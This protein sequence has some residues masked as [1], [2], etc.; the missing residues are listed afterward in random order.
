MHRLAAR[1]LRITQTGGGAVWAWTI[2]ELYV[3]AA[4]GGAAPAAVEADGAELARGLR[5]EGVRRLYAD[6]GWASRVALA[7]PAIWIPPANLQVDDYGFTGPATMLL[8]PFHWAAGTGVLLESADAEAFAEAARAGGLAF[9]RRSLAGLSLFV[10]VSIPSPGPLLS[11]HA[12]GVTAARRSKRARLAVDGDPATRWATARPRAAGDW[13]RVDLPAAR[14]LR[15]VRLSVDESRRPAAGA[16]PGGLARRRGLG[17][18]R[19]EGAVGAQ[20][21]MGWLRSSR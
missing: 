3:Y 9:A 6:H 18:P 14:S 20:V 11:T 13:F 15:G 1:H 7:D 16:G 4:I 10:H 2:R 8:P 5:A 17:A 19:R 12:L 21:S